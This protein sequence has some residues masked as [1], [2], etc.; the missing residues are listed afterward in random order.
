MLSVAESTIAFLWQR[1]AK[2]NQKASYDFREYGND[3]RKTE[4][5]NKVSFEVSISNVQ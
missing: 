5:D 3:F 4:V 1:S 2:A